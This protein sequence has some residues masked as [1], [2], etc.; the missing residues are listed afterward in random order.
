[1]FLCLQTNNRIKECRNN[2]CCRK[3][4]GR[5]H[6]S[7]CVPPSQE[8]N[9]TI[10]PI[11]KNNTS[12]SEQPIEEKEQTTPT[13]VAHSQTKQKVLLQT[14]RTVAYGNDETRT[15]PIRVLFDSCSQRT[16]IKNELKNK[17]N[18]K[19]I[20]TETVF[21]NTFRSEKY[22]KQKCDVVKVR[23][24]AKYDEDVELTAI[25][26]DKICSPLPV[27]VNVQEY[28]HLDGLAFAD[29]LESEKDQESIQ[30]L[31]G[32]NRYWDL[33]TNEIIKGPEGESGPI[34][35]Q[36]KFGW[37][38]AGPVNN[39]DQNDNVY[40]NV[41]NLLIDGIQDESE[42]SL[43]YERVEQDELVDTLKSSGKS[44]NWE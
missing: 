41:T 1:M 12:N 30:I 4:S 23:L 7:L 25:C 21:L 29:S 17:L 33:T 34:A 43:N 37:L 18:M 15:V 6:Q 39:S 5:H 9:E 2:I 14:A 24:K 13:S 40:F 10:A 36:S 26:Y 42:M 31:I 22:V 28:V 27:K 19:L 20:R 16:F 38:I 35:M 3:C 44:R 11:V 8:T 32:S